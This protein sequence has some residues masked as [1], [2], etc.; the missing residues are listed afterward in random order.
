M[1][2]FVSGV[3]MSALQIFQKKHQRKLRCSGTF[4]PHFLFHSENGGHIY[5]TCLFAVFALPPP[6]FICS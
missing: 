1:V 6:A 2:R 5:A 4:S 3:V